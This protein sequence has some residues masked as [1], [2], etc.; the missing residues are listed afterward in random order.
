[1]SKLRVLSGKDIIKFLQK[2]GL[3]IEY[4]KGSHCKLFKLI[5]GE[6]ESITI[7]LHK[8]IAKG[9]L[10]AIYNQASRFVSQGELKKYF[11]SD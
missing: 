2:E 3:E 10:R 4:G 1:M 5:G 6:K 8:E 9:T 11:Y 7:P